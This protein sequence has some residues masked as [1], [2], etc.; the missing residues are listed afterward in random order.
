MWEQSPKNSLCSPFHANKCTDGLNSLA[1]ITK[2]RIICVSPFWVQNKILKIVYQSGHTFSGILSQRSHLCIVAK[3]PT[4][5]FRLLFLFHSVC[6]WK[7]KSVT[8]GFV[9]VHIYL[10]YAY[11]VLFKFW[12]ICQCLKAKTS[13]LPNSL[14]KSDTGAGVWSWLILSYRPCTLFFRTQF[15]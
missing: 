6:V 8:Y 9:Q 5:Y 7:S 14:E 3:T 15:Q 11:H 13:P 2:R 4:Y 12:M 10:H 1:N